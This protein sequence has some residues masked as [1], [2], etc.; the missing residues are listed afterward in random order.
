MVII[1]S[2]L[3]TYDHKQR[4]PYRRHLEF[5]RTCLD[6]LLKRVA[7]ELGEI[8]DKTLAYRAVHNFLEDEFQTA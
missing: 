7:V 2:I 1:L 4:K 6:S 3:E 8:S 5:E